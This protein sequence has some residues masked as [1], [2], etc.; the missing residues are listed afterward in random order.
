MN[1]KASPVGSSLKM[2]LVLETLASGNIAASI[3]EFPQ[4]RVEAASRE[5]A[6]AQV[7]ANASDWF[8]RIELLP[9]EI[10][11]KNLDSPWIKYA[12]MFEG[13]A[14]FAEIAAALR[15]ERETDD[16]SEV[17]PAVY[18]RLDDRAPEH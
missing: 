12:G 14:D 3:L 1:L 5:S 17:D 2:T 7:Q 18:A 6:I 4:Y 8:D 16:D 13:D 15:A 9:M 10:P 11:S